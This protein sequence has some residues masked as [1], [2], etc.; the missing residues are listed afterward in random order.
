MLLVLGSMP[1]LKP[2]SC[3]LQSDFQKLR[4]GKKKGKILLVSLCVIQASLQF[5]F[6]GIFE[7]VYR[8]KSMN[9][10]MHL[11]SARTQSGLAKNGSSQ[12][13]VVNFEGI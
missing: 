13:S 9:A 1:T 5:V 12:V 6:S 3:V 2:L 10:D 11:Q 7:R 8:S 4:K